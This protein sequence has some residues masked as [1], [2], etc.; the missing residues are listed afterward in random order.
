M[1]WGEPEMKIHGPKHTQYNPY[2]NQAQNMKDIKNK[3]NHKDRLEISSEAQ[4][5]QQKKQASLDR[6]AY[7]QDIKQAVQSGNYKINHEKTA[8]KMIDFWTGK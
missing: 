1:K 6:E 3:P 2:K 5:L 8:Q 7:V 4:Q